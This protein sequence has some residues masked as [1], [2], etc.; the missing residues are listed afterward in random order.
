[1]MRLISSFLLVSLL[2]VPRPLPAQAADQ[3]IAI[4]N[5]LRAIAECAEGQKANADFQKKYDVRRD[6]LAKKQKELQDLQQQLAT[7]GGTMTDEARAALS[8]SIEQKTVTLQRSQ[9]DAEKEFT[10]L[11]NEIFSRIGTKMTPI[12]QQYAKEKNFTLLL[13]YSSQTGQLF[14]VDPALDVTDSI[15]KRYDGLQASQKGA[16]PATPKQPA[17]QSQKSATTA[18]PNKMPGTAGKAPVT[19]PQKN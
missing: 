10:N 7:Q 12:V 8:R 16:A 5:V 15:I 13:D 6:E 19:P 17:A 18:Q 2:A 11:R 1:M 4:I 9:D 14:Y 3:K